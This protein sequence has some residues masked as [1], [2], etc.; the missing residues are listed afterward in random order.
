MKGKNIV[1]FATLGVCLYEEIKHPSENKEHIHQEHY[2]I[3]APHT[4][5]VYNI[6]GRVQFITVNAAVLAIR[7][8]G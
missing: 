7:D 5:D 6:S 1:I 8:L 4:V 3:L 2:S